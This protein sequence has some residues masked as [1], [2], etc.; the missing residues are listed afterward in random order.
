ML[1]FFIY[2]KYVEMDNTGKNVILIT[3]ICN[4]NNTQHFKNAYDESELPPTMCNHYTFELD[5]GPL[6]SAL[7]KSYQ[8][9][10]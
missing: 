6:F 9:T 7:F 2:S 1:F 10:L 5:E 8:T 4:T 3:F